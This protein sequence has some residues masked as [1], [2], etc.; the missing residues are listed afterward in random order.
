[1]RI[2]AQEFWLLSFSAALLTYEATASSRSSRVVTDF[3]KERELRIPFLGMGYRSNPKQ[4]TPLNSRTH[5][6]PI[7][8]I[9]F[10]THFISAYFKFLAVLI[11]CALNNLAY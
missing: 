7:T 6:S 8:V 10:R 2:L 4:E 5:R 1:M 3:P 9:L 11:P